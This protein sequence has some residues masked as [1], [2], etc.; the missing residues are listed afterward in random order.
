MDWRES[1]LF[2]E[3]RNG[4]L[5]TSLFLPRVHPNGRWGWT[6]SFRPGLW[7]CHCCELFVVVVF[8]VVMLYD[9]DRSTGLVYDPCPGYF[10]IS[11][12]RR[13]ACPFG[14]WCPYSVRASGAA[15]GRREGV[16]WLVAR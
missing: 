5:H 9:S 6:W 12:F 15:P 10:G 3:L 13:D 14:E 1:R 11:V 4:D 2:S 8:T 7:N 16:S